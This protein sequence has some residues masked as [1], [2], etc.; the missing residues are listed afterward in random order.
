MAAPDSHPANTSFPAADCLFCHDIENENRPLQNVGLPAWP[1]ILIASRLL[2]KFLC[3][4][5]SYSARDL[6]FARI[7]THVIRLITIY[8]NAVSGML[9]LCYGSKKEK[10]VY[11]IT[12]TR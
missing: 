2:I 9:Q 4:A 12:R 10:F 6:H 11:G 8:D 1:G 7:Q 3:L 5:F